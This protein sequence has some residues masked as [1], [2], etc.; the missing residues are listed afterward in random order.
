MTGSRQVYNHA[1]NPATDPS[2]ADLEEL[3]YINDQN[4]ANY[5]R[6]KLEAYD[7]LWNML[8]VDVT[9]DFINRFTVCFK[10]FVAPER[11][12]LYVTEDDE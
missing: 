7:T 11:P 1:S 5:K 8:K 3:D 4:T 12:L 10:R 9:S 2:T 6:G